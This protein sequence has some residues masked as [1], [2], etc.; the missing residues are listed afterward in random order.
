M[1]VLAIELIDLLINEASDGESEAGLLLHLK[2][3]LKEIIFL[4][5]NQ[6]T[7]IAEKSSLLV[8]SMRFYWVDNPNNCLIFR[9]MCCWFGF[10][11]ID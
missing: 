6:I 4:I 2:T 11:A 10:C 7:C 3:V 1:G 5:A 9:R 8:G